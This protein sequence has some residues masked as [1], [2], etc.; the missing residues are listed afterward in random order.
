MISLAGLQPDQDI[1]IEYIGLR[2]G[3]KLFE[4]LFDK[5]EQ[6]LAA[7]T[8]GVLGAI[9]QPMAYAVLERAFREIDKAG[10]HGDAATVRRLIKNLLPSYV[11]AD[12]GAAAAEDDDKLLVNGAARAQEAATPRVGGQ[13]LDRGAPLS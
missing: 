5:T 4:E 12:E 9:S 11:G 1:K 2:E 6:R 10:S 13:F 7:V 8:D 3:E